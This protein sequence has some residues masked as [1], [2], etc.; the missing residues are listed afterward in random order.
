MVPHICGKVIHKLHEC[1]STIQSFQHAKVWITSEI[2]SKHG[3]LYFSCQQHAA[4][5][6]GTLVA[7][8]TIN[9]A[10]TQ[11]ADIW[12]DALAVLHSS[13]LSAREKGWFED[14]VPEA[15]FGT[16]I[17]LWR[18]QRRGPADIADHAQRV[19]DE[20]ATDRLGTGDVPR[21]Q[22]RARHRGT[23]RR[24]AGAAARQARP[25]RGTHAG[26]SRRPS[27]RMRARPR[28]RA[29]CPSPP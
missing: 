13:T 26:G 3:L 15:V 1:Y 24:A 22:D 6:K 14:V 23:P 16:T 5:R 29:S 19:I 21:V 9:P 18:Q 12:S 25:A 17:V 4:M 11:A 20:C 10:A 7:D 28:S 8:T 27:T 2:R